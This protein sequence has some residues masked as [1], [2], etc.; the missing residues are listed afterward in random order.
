[1]IEEFEDD[2]L[3]ESLEELESFIKNNQASLKKENVN[4]DNIVGIF[5]EIRKVQDEI[6][7][8]NKELYDRTSKTNKP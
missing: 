5:N 4:I 7:K 8:L 2:E 1:M 6:E 3:D